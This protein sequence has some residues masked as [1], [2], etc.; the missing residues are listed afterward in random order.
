MMAT[1]ILPANHN[2]RS[3]LTRWG[4]AGAVVLA[5]HVGF[6][7]AY[8]LLRPLQPQGAEDAPA[9]IID[10]EP[11]TVAPTVQ[12]QDLAPG[13]ELP[14]PNPEAMDP[15]KHEIAEPAE[16]EPAPTISPLVTLPEPKPE[17]KPKAVEKQNEPVP[18]PLSRPQTAPPK[19]ERTAP[20]PAAARAGKINASNVQSSWVRQ[21]LAHLNRYKQY[22]PAARSRREE[23]VVTLS[24]TMD[25]DGLILARR[26]AN[27]S[28]SKLLDAE[29]LAML[30]RAEPLPPFPASMAGA[31][32]SFN[33]PI[34]FSLR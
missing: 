24:F 34:R 12:R 15:P 26:V 16:I 6:I 14:P 21:L 22:P 31:S 7:A 17:P 32:R 23:G 19:A 1:T 11:L 8:W 20:V 18:V 29:A 3:D 28:G 9:V 13:P 25:R 30:R 27:S 10:L 4:G 33:V 2:S 5:A